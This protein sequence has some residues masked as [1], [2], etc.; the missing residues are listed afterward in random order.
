ME[1][2][3]LANR[4]Q[5]A[6]L[7]LEGEARQKKR[8]SDK[9]ETES[10]RREA[11]RALEGSERHLAKEKAEQVIK[12]AELAVKQTAEAAAE[13][14]RAAAQAAAASRAATEQANQNRRT[15]INQAE[16]TI[17]EI[18]KAPASL[19][20]I[21]TL[22][23]Y[24]TE[25]ADS[26]KISL[27]RI[28]LSTEEKKRVDNLATTKSRRFGGVII[29]LIIFLLLVGGG[30]YFFAF[31]KINLPKEVNPPISTVLKPE[32]LIFA[33]K[34]K[35]LA[36]EKSSARE[37]KRQINEEIMATGDAD[38]VLEL[39]FTNNN[40]VVNFRFWQNL[41]ALGRTENFLS[42]LGT[43]FMLGI[44]GKGSGSFLAL[45]ITDYDRAFA[46]M[47]AWEKTLAI[48]LGEI[49]AGQ[50][51]NP[52]REAKF[53]DQVLKNID[54]REL[55]GFVVYGFLNRNLLIIAKNNTVFGEVIDRSRQAGQ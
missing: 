14:E 33:E 43:K 11:V 12:L 44:Y 9:E 36:L 41:L 54:T 13:K 40:Q 25:A 52:P 34:H 7:A 10:R 53:T 47:L 1:N 4:R 48:D 39:F 42:A 29:V 23:T 51:V 45:T 55:G 19:S 26:E 32:S 8:E 46:G 31:S 30:A 35:V 6:R 2:Q 27:T 38:E 3:D 16:K 24:L 5:E 17:Q 28:A 20:G 50:T 21:R 49:L 18:K 15:N 37:L 22:K